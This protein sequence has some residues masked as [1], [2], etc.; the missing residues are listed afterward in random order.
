MKLAI[1]AFLI[2]ATILVIFFPTSICAYDDFGYDEG[3]S[4]N[5]AGYFILIICVAVGISGIIKGHD[6]NYFLRKY[7]KPIIDIV[8]SIGVLFIIGAMTHY[9][10]DAS[11]NIWRL[12]YIIFFGCTLALLL[13]RFSRDHPLS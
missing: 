12:V 10:N 8:G 6:K 5:A 7:I 2:I 4:G 9:I 1:N 13:E 11:S 3:N